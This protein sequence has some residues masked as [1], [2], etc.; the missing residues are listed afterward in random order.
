MAAVHPDE[1][2]RGADEMEQHVG[3]PEQRSARRGSPRRRSAPLARRRRRSPAR[4]RR[5]RPC[6]QAPPRR[7][8]RRR[9]GRPRRSRRGR[10]DRRSHGDRSG[11]G[12]ARREPCAQPRASRRRDHGEI[13]PIEVRQTT[14][15][16]TRGASV[17]FASKLAPTDAGVMAE[18]M[19]RT[20]PAELPL[21][22]REARERRR[23]G[24]VRRPGQRGRRAAERLARRVRRREVPAPRQ[25]GWWGCGRAV[26]AAR[27]EPPGAAR[28]ASTSAARRSV[29]KTARSP[30]ATAVRAGAV[31]PVEPVDQGGPGY[32]GRAY[33]V[34]EVG[35]RRRKRPWRRRR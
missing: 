12:R 18:K 22:G 5:C 14:P 20:P 7:P 27:E 26:A 19:E 25:W 11:S 21:V 15:P 16:G 33:C 34:D 8:R 23:R 13:T 24:R 28:S 29:W 1:R 31:G 35:R 3:E 2:D 30:Q 9:R 17:R 32:P 6:S 4:P 10:R